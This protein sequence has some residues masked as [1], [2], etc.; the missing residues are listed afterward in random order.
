MH[1][2]VLEEVWIYGKGVELFANGRN[3]HHKVFEIQT[4]RDGATMWCVDCLRSLKRK[5]ERE[6]A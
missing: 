3:I 1:R 4:G 5:R 2:V 6:E